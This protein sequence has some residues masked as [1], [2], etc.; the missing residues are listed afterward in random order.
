MSD[1]Q[2]TAEA[3][4]TSLF[5][6]LK[7]EHE[8]DDC[9]V[10]E[11]IRSLLVN[12]IIDSADMYKTSHKDMYPPLTTLIGTYSEAQVGGEL[13]YVVMFGLQKLLN[14]LQVITVTKAHIEEA[15]A[16]FKE[17]F[18]DDT[19]FERIRPGWEKIVANGGKLPIAIHA[20][21][22]GS[23]V[24]CG[25]P[26]MTIE[27]TDPDVPWIANYLETRLSHLWYTCT[28]ATVAFN[29]RHELERC[30]VKEG[31]TPECAAPKA[32][33]SGICDFGL[34]G[35]PD[36]SAGRM[37]SYPKFLNHVQDAGWSVQNIV[38]GS[39]GGLLQNAKSQPRHIAFRY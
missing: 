37:Y 9:I 29:N 31:V 1:T 26:L 10:K 33:I 24:P 19:V 5:A 21:P 7:A 14:E 16:F 30:L 2:N 36:Q 8:L 22:E 28:V 23:V 3:I 27:A 11:A 17:T 18:G 35:V 39:G 32:K 38:C 12:P 13:D 4:A 6:R 15:A 20:L 25:T 34:R